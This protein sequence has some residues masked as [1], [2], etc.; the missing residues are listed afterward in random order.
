MDRRFAEMAVHDDDE[1]PF[2]VVDGEVNYD[3]LYSFRTRQTARKTTDR[4]AKRRKVSSTR[5]HLGASQGAYDASEEVIRHMAKKKRANKAQR[6][7]G[8][9][10]TRST[11]AQPAQRQEGQ[12]STSSANTRPRPP[13]NSA[14]SAYV[15]QQT[16]TPRSAYM[17]TV[18]AADRTA[19]DTKS[20]QL[21]VHDLNGMQKALLDG[22]S[23][24]PL[25]KQLVADIEHTSAVL[26]MAAR[27][28]A[29][30][31]ESIIR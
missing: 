16:C 10:S 19:M 21:A 26:E 9:G 18:E 30:T 1:N 4:P 2:G 12:S 28:V 5:Q 22:I 20:V 7:E 31:T 13:Q 8:H 3:E 27:V 15:T 6:Q 23:Q 24:G 14:G 17:L 25:D 11:N 29:I